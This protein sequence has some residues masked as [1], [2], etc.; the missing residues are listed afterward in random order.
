MLIAL[1]ASLRVRDLKP[2]L[3]DGARDALINLSIAAYE[4]KHQLASSRLLFDDIE[5]LSEL[6]TITLGRFKEASLA[7]VEARA[8]LRTAPAMIRVEPIGTPPSV[9]STSGRLVFEVPLDYF[10]DSQRL[11]LACIVAENPIDVSLY[12]A[13]GEAAAVSNTGMRCRL[14]G[15]DG[16]GGGTRDTFQSQIDQERCVLC[17]VDSDRT[18]PQGPNGRT[19]D[20]VL[21]VRDAAQAANKIA[22]AHVLPCRELENLL[23]ANLVCDALPADPRDPHRQRVLA[24]QARLGLADHADLK[25]L[26]KLKQISAFFTQL[27]PQKRHDHYFRSPSNPALN[28]VRELILSFGLAS[29]PG[30]T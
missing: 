17:I 10:A 25:H 6:G 12:L 2:R 3:A 9:Q 26:V 5:T 20:D 29:R 18:H 11:A 4:G 15:L 19:A 7:A 27:S 1:S 8:L 30:R 23:P 16:H 22:E 13:L 14:H 21:A 28:T 24:T